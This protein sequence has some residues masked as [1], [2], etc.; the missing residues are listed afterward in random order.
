MSQQ[1]NI[2]SRVVFSVT[3]VG[4][5]LPHSRRLS[6]P[7]AQQ[8]VDEFYEINCRRLPEGWPDGTCIV[9]HS[10]VLTDEEKRRVSGW[11]KRE[12][13]AALLRALR[14]GAMP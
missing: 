13:D 6:I 8:F 14:L 3:F 7:E 12:R 1:V 9:D 11:A 10:I 4:D 5:G 2:K